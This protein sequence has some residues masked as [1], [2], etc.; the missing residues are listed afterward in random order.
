MGALLS[1]TQDQTEDILITA[2][3]NDTIYAHLDN[4]D[5]AQLTD[6]SLQIAWNKGDT[7]FVVGPG[8]LCGY[9]FN[10]NSG[11]RSGS[12]TAVPELNIYENSADDKAKID[13]VDWEGLYDNKYYAICP[14][15]GYYKSTS[16]KKIYF[17]S[18][19]GTSDLNSAIQNYNPEGSDPTINRVFGESV[20]GKNFVFKNKFGYL[21]VS[22]TGEKVVKKL[23]LIN[24]SNSLEEIIAG[25]YTFYPDDA[26][27]KF[28]WSA[29]SYSITMNCGEGVQ[30]S[31][32]PTHFYFAVAPEVMSQGMILQVDFTDG[33]SFI[34]RSP[35]EITI[36]RSTLKPMAVLH[37]S[38]AKYQTINVTYEGES[39]T[40][41]EFVGSDYLTGY[42][43]WGDG[44][45]DILNL[46]TSHE[47]NDDL[48]SHKTI[49]NVRN[50]EK[51]KF[52]G[53]YGITELDFSNF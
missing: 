49:I 41:P 39:F 36:E 23:V 30:L 43:N 46:V 6:S 34:Q 15:R 42:I 38:E 53:C 22:L 28:R 8:K 1:C 3:S 25:S 21:R 26:L 20:D 7:I 17:K 5:R 24:A 35:K 27:D 4:E 45:N 52:T 19:D 14:Y 37:T 31:A 40:L 2:A 33:T 51:V 48:S 44:S 29:W 47:Y 9:I 16:N 10:G 12:F 11:D 18:K 32:T 50:A 13:A